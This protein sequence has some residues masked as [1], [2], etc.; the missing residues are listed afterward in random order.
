MV[1]VP[2]ATIRHGHKS[3]GQGCVSL[4]TFSQSYIIIELIIT[5]NSCTSRSKT[6]LVHGRGCQGDKVIKNLLFSASFGY[7]FRVLFDLDLVLL[8]N[9]S[10]NLLPLAEAK[11]TVART[12]TRRAIRTPFLE[13]PIRNSVSF[14]KINTNETPLACHWH[15]CR[16]QRT[17]THNMLLRHLVRLGLLG[18]CLGVASIINPCG[19][20]KPEFLHE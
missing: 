19:I 4:H 5:E 10:A 17:H 3:R 16:K 12:V 14:H 6:A 15:L 8:S 7:L 11:V 13:V 9:P 18:L 20:C 2:L 1:D